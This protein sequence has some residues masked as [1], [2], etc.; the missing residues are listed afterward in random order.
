M[1]VIM[2]GKNVLQI[3]FDQMDKRLELHVPIICAHFTFGKG[4]KCF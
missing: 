1:I 2:R 3:F 4:L